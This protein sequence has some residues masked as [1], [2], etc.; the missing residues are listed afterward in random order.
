MTTTRGAVADGAERT[1]RGARESAR[2]RAREKEGE[3]YGTGTR[4]TCVVTG[5]RR[6]RVAGLG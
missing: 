5:L 1:T 6:A 2:E 3:E 4:N